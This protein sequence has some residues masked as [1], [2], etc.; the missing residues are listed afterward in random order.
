[1]APELWDVMIVGAGPA[2]SSLAARLGA[3]GWSVLLLDSARFPRDKMCGEYIGAG[4]LPLLRDLGAQDELLRRGHPVRFITARSPGGNE[5]R[6]D[7][8]EA[9]FGLSL[10]RR[11]LDSIL[12]ERA[13]LHGSV[14]V[15]EGFRAEGPVF[16]DGAVCGVR[17][18]RPGGEIE[19]LRARITV[20]ADGRNSAIARGLGAFRLHPR[21]SK[22]ALGIHYEGV[23]AAGEC[24]EIYA[25]R[26][27]YGI[28]N[29]QGSGRANVCI[30]TRQADLKLWKGNLDCSASV[31]NG[32]SVLPLR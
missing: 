12:L 9:A 26:S 17:V 20:G 31:G 6:A 2:G 25:G 24:A 3:S 1:L 18:R 21:H 10:S 11:V 14:E 23:Q 27:V 16:E 8:P 32:E 5:F 4:C 28:L 15:R 29:H 30:V 13:R 7:Y 19:V 22:L